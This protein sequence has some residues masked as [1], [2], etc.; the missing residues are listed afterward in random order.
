MKKQIVLTAL[1]VALSCGAALSSL[2]GAWV[3]ETGSGNWHYDYL[4]RGVSEGFLK[5]QWA[6]LDGNQDGVSECYYF[7][8]EG[9]MLANTTVNGSAVNANGQWTV[10]GVV[11]TRVNGVAGS[12]ENTTELVN[13]TP[14][15]SA[16]YERFEQ[17]E[18]ASGLSWTDGFRLSGD[19]SHAAYASFQLDKQYSLLT[20][21]FSP[22][23]GQSGKQK[24][25]V[26]VTGLTS[27]RSLYR[28]DTLSPDSA[29]VSVTLKVTNEEAVRINVIRGYDFL[30]DSV[31]VQ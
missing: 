3:H 5:N 12:L 7:D 13:T 19:L 15:E 25:R 27:G 2:A 21:T 17:A 8:A 1:T 11:Q 24:G 23:A 31:A 10:D 4:G 9:V 6:W 30:F 29:P 26:S 16:Y 14:K 22:A 20:L 28:S 18:T